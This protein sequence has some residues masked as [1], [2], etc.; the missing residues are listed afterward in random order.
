[1]K[2]FYFSLEKLLNYKNQELNS[3]LYVLGA[4]QGALNRMIAEL[5][6]LREKLNAYSCEYTNKLKAGTTV[7]NIEF[8]CMH[9]QLTQTKILKKEQQIFLQNNVINTQLDKVKE[10]KANAS[11]IEKLK[12]R[13]LVE[14]NKNKNKQFNIFIDELVCSAKTIKR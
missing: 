1:M 13:K 2:Q 4:M 6:E 5:N 10:K 3:E 11:V 12:E 7:N 14:Y 8:I 9:I